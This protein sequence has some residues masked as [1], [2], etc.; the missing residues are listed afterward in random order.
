MQ[1]Q[2]GYSEFANVFKVSPVFSEN[3]KGRA[4]KKRGTEVLRKELEPSILEPSA[5]KRVLIKGWETYTR[6]KTNLSY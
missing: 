3:E 4:L 1:Y 6:G 2:P 5:G